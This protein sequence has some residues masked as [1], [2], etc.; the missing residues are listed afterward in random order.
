[1]ER[2]WTIALAL[3]CVLMTAAAQI[4][5]KVGVSGSSLQAELGVGNTQAFLLR[6]LISPWVIAG[7]ALYAI[8]TVLWLLVLGRVD[9][10]YAYP[11]VS[12]GF[13]FTALYGYL[14]LNEPMGAFR[15][16]GIALIITGVALVSKS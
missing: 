5:L 13:A 2:F 11:F 10:S 16:A 14:V 15:V 9:V 6:A 1:M 3:G 8:S 12:L 7:L 4:C